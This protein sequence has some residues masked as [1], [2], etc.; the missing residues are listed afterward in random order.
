M[1]IFDE[2]LEAKAAE[3]EAVKRRRIIEDMMVGAFDVPE[4]F[5]GTKNVEAEGFKVKINGRINR[6]VDAERLQD[7]AAEHGLTE[8]LSSLFRWKPEINMT[9]WKAAD[10]AITRPLLDAITAT[11]GRPSFTITK[12][13]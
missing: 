9:L 12:A 7:I 10:V 2:W 1:S 3:A 11:P 4:D 8:H 6:K 13:E 5:E